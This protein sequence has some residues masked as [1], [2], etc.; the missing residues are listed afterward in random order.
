MYNGRLRDGSKVVVKCLRLKQRYSPQ[1]MAQF[2]DGISKL[3][4]RHL[5]SILGHCIDDEPEDSASRHCMYLMLEAVSNGN[6]RSHLT[7]E[8]NSLKALFSA[9][10]KHGGILSLLSPL[11]Y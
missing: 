2:I 7:G 5:V 8:Q 9:E 10:L 6:L 4:H 3:R 11:S 1:S